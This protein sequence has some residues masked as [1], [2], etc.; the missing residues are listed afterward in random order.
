MMYPAPASKAVVTALVPPNVLPT[1]VMNPPV[2]GWARENWD[3]VLPS[4]AIAMM[5]AMTVSQRRSVNPSMLASFTCTTSHRPSG[6]LGSRL[7]KR[8][9]DSCAPYLMRRHARKGC[10]TVLAGGRVREGALPEDDLAGDWD[11][12]WLG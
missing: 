12:P 1:N 4:S 7:G 5:A 9:P 10:H 8:F 11:D 3:S 6:Q 2:L